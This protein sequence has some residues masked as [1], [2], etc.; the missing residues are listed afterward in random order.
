MRRPTEDPTEKHIKNFAILVV[1]RCPTVASRRCFL[2]ECFL[3]VFSFKCHKSHL[4]IFKW[5]NRY[6]T[7]GEGLIKTRLRGARVQSRMSVTLRETAERD[8]VAQES[9][10]DEA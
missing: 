6:S 2:N 8:V 3:D 5:N 9:S 7:T 10:G 1:L 4:E